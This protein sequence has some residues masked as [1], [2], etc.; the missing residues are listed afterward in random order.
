M[1]CYR[2]ITLM[3]KTWHVEYSARADKAFSKMDPFDRKLILSWIDKNLEGCADPRRYGK[4]LTGD[5]AKEWR[6]RIGDYR[7]IAE[8]R[9]DRILVLVIAIGHRSDIYKK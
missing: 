4:G 7:V 9:D 1:R 6:Y 5:R 3:N 2:N 8:I